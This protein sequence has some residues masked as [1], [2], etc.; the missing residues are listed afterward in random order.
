MLNKKEIDILIVD[1]DETIL[2]NY[3]AF[4][5]KENYRVDTASSISQASL[6]IIETE[7]HVVIIDAENIGI[8]NNFLRSLQK[9]DIHSQVIINSNSI[10]KDIQHKLQTGLCYACVVKQNMVSEELLQY[11]KQAEELYLKVKNISRELNERDQPYKKDIDWIIWQLRKKQDSQYIMGIA[12][13]ETLVHTVFQGMGLGSTIS[14]LDLIH[15]SKQEDGQN[16]IIKTNLMNLLLKNSDPMRNIKSNLDN[17]IHYLKCEYDKEIVTAADIE[18]IIDESLKKTDCFRAIKE[19]NVV[20]SRIS[21]PDTL[22]SNKKFLGV[23]FRELFTNSYKYSPPNSKILLT[24]GYSDI[25][26]SIILINSIQKLSKGISGI[27]KE[28]EN[29]VFEPFFR[30]NKIYDERFNLEELGFGVGLA[31]L[32]KG[33]SSLG[34]KIYIYEAMDHISSFEPQ[35]IIITEIIFRRTEK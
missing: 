5:E 11:I 21:F 17:L 14:V 7:P 33:F 25:G 3:K 31:I 12:I 30:I 6:I 13:L 22:I 35:R 24:Q 26:L 28:Y 15:M 29:Q 19:Q 16:T 4:L 9:I 20:R 27:P 8:G 18:N 2:K 23:C 10:S 32:K 34:G 1:N